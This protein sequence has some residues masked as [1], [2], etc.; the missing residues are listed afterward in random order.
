[1]L[2][3]LLLTLGLVTVFPVQA[4]DFNTINSCATGCCSKSGYC[5]VGDGYCGADCGLL[6]SCKHGYTGITEE[7]CGNKKV[8]K[9]LANFNGYTPLNRIV[10]Y[11]EGWSRKR[12]CHTFFPEQIPLGMYTHLNY[13]FATIDPETFEVKLASSGEENLVRCLARLKTQDPYLKVSIAIGG[14]AYNDPGPTQTTFSD[15]AASQDAQK[16]FFESL[17]SFLSTYSLDGVDIDWR[18]PCP[19]DI[20][21]RNGR[22]EDFKNFPAFLQHL[23]QA[24]KTAGG[25]DGLT[26]TLSASYWF[27]QYF[28][29][30]KLEKYVDFFNILTY[31]LHGAGDLRNTSLDPYLNAHKNLTEI[32]DAMDLVWC[33]KIPSNKVILGNGFYGR[34]FPATSASCMEPGCTYESA[35]SKGLCSNENG[36]L[37]NSKI[38]DIIEG[39]GPTPKLYKEAA[40]NLLRLP[41]S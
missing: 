26:I 9:P 20:V 3:R 15:L 12:N 35:A 36:I 22:E 23:K 18:Y 39:K 14:W 21:K 38:V 11:Y 40:V 41:L 30:V 4:Q 16:K 34:P 10:G 27:L 19:D 37:P 17:I 29:I 25:R 28:D 5:G 31:D 33:N 2:A 6:R 32:Q 24:L 8:T 13:A 1:M 7:F